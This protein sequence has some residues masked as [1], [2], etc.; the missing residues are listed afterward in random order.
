LHLLVYHIIKP[1]RGLRAG[2]PRKPSSI[3]ERLKDFTPGYGA[4]TASCSVGTWDYF[5]RLK[6]PGSGVDHSPLANAEVKNK[7]SYTFAPPYVLTAS[8]V[9]IPQGLSYLCYPQI[10]FMP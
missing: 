1:R 10:A 3:P 6:W 4:H 2:Q 9:I 7:W 5:L 8:P